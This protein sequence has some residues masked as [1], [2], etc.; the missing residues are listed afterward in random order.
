MGYPNAFLVQLPGIGVLSAMVIF[1]A[2]GE[3]SRFP[4]AKDLVGYSGLGGRIYAS[5]QVVHQG[6]ITKQGRRTAG[7][8]PRSS[9]SST[10]GV[11]DSGRAG[12][13]LEESL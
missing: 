6:S 1:S 13:F 3:I 10:Q 2:I 7:V 8:T 5:A 9:G 4:T 11:P 12:R